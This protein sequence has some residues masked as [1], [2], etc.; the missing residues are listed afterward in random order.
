MTSWLSR[1]KSKYVTRNQN[2]LE[3]HSAGAMETFFNENFFRSLITTFLGAIFAILVAIGG[4]W[5][6]GRESRQAA[7]LRRRQLADAL[8][9]SLEFNLKIA[10]SASEISDQIFLTLNVDTS[11]FEATRSLKYEVMSDINLSRDI[12]VIGYRLSSLSRQIELRFEMEFSGSFL[13]YSGRNQLREAL[14]RV[15]RAAGASLI[16]YESDKDVLNRLEEMAGPKSPVKDG[17]PSTRST[18]V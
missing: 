6:S 12:D 1:R 14:S 18:V 10:H 9:E 15:I 16:D 5:L 8:R 11:I 4:W 2:N 17:E 13:A 3:A 7:S